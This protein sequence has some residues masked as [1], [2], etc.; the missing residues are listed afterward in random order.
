GAEPGGYNWQLLEARRARGIA[1]LLAREPARAAESLGDAWEHLEREGVDEL[2]A[3]PVAAD[4]VEAFVELERLDDARQGLDRLQRLANEQRHGW[5][6]VTARRCDAL[7]RLVSRD[8]DEDAALALACAV[9]DYG[10]LGLRFDAARSLLSL[11]RA[12][13]RH[14]KWGAARSS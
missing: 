2:G 12:Q 13:R 9:E 3:F 11:G 7:L 4:L 5:G 10:T 14:R 6:L 1:A 8:Y